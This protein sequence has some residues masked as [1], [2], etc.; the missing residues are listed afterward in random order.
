MK[1]ISDEALLMAAKQV[2]KGNQFLVLAQEN[3]HEGVLGI[4]AS[5]W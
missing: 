1:E 2:E 5:K 3:W 4:T